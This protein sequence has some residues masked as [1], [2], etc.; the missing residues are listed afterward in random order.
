MAR[1]SGSLHPITKEIQFSDLGITFTAHPVTK[2]L[3]VHRNAEAVK[4]AVKNLILTRHFER[5]YEPLFGSN[6]NNRLF[7]N[8]DPVEEASLR[9]DIREAIS[10]YEPRAIVESVDVNANF[11]HNELYINIRF[12]VLNQVAPTELQ[13]VVQRTR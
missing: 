10:N 2:R 4:R 8:F 12:R 6:V 1:N 9:A 3:P 7:E 5:P 11:D 13:V